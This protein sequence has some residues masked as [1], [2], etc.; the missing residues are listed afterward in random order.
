[1]LTPEVL[2]VTPQ[3]RARLKKLSEIVNPLGAHWVKLTRGPS[4]R[5][6]EPLKIGRASSGRA[7]DLVDSERAPRGSESTWS[8]TQGLT[9]SARGTAATGL[10]IHK[11][12][13]AAA[14]VAIGL[15][16]MYG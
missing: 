7:L 2:S 4:D 11:L 6:L 14:I 13:C 12:P 8:S 15:I 1:M 16:H 9:A 5:R 10:T 3:V